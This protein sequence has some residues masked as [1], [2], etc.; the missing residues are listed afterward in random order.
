MAARAQRGAGFTLVEL[1][2]AIT[3]L[4]VVATSI[5]TSFSLGLR[6]RS[7]S[8]ARAT[9]LQA[10][11]QLTALLREDLRNLAPIAP[12]LA[13]TDGRLSLVRKSDER[14]ARA[15]G[16]GGTPPRL[17]HVT[18]G[19]AGGD[20][21]PIL[22]RRERWLDTDR[23]SSLAL[24]ALLLPGPERAAP[25][26]GATSRKGIREWSFPP[27]ESLGLRAFK[28]QGSRIVEART[29][30]LTDPAR[31]EFSVATA[32]DT[33]S[34]VTIWLPRITPRPSTEELLP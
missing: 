10:N 31:F 30:L 11:R 20:T 14:H 5:Y 32:H 2:V 4:L 34:A 29:G 17:I 16:P 28:W 9:R 18:Y 13:V 15:A 24:T 25:P 27:V 22:T 3:I 1:I 7:D 8:R 26:S 21:D 6:V 23:L 19:P 12:N 33:S